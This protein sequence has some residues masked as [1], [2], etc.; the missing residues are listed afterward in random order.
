MP[1]Q[2]HFQSAW[3][4]IP[5]FTDWMQKDIGDSTNALCS[6]CMKTISLKNQ[7]ITA[8]KIHATGIKHKKG[9]IL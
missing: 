5:E 8:L 9:K 3:L 7:G 2:C 4:N 6:V 1:G